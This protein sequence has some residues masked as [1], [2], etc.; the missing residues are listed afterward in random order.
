MRTAV[1]EFE[2]YEVK[3]AHIRFEENG[4]LTE[5]EELG[6]TGTLSIETEMRTIQKLCAGEVIKETVKATRLNGT[7]SLHLNPDV[8]IAIFG[9]N[10]TDL[11]KGVYGYNGKKTAKGIITFDVY[12][13]YGEERKLLAFPKINFTSGLVINIESGA[14]E[15]AQL[16]LP[17]SGLKDSEGYFYYQAF[18]KDIEEPTL[19][20][21]WHSD[22]TPELVIATPVV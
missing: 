8:A 17:F 14:E 22:F 13:M 6:C 2:D 7:S 12:D 10:N 16:E 20:D 1:T 9:L 5:A 4:E 18:A 3:N 21:A 11:L 19:I 15:V